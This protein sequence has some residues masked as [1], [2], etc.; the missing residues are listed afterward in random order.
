MGVTTINILTGLFAEEGERG[1]VFGIIG[2]T[3]AL[4]SVIGG[5]T[6]GPIVDRWGFQGLFM[7]EALFVIIVPLSALFLNDKVVPRRQNH[8]TA[9]AGRGVLTS[10]SF[11]L[12]FFASLCVFIA[13]SEMVLAKPLLMDGLHFDATAISNTVTVG[14]LISLPL[15][16]LT[17]RLSDHIG[18]KPLLIVLYLLSI[19]GLIITAYALYFWHFALAA[20]LQSTIGATVVVGS[21]LV[22]DVVSPQMLGIALSWFAATNW[23]GYIVG[24]AG[25]G[26]AIKAFGT[27]ATLMFGVLL[28]MIA[29][30][31]LISIRQPAPSLQVESG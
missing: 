13:N 5:L 28:S 22:T 6:S 31:L 20:V 29:V 17:G 30:V 18:R 7:L 14:G 1:K 3:V 2:S 9:S 26:N 25:T 19:V 24:F 8:T 16:F 27:T 21:A 23:V 10:R 11:L 15:P 4:G 12:L